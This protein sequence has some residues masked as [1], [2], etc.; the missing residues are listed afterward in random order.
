MSDKYTHTGLAHR[1]ACE[2][3]RAGTD[4]K[5]ECLDTRRGVLKGWRVTVRYEEDGEIRRYE[6]RGATPAE[7]AADFLEANEHLYG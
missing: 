6:G 5:A 1:E 2:A 4:G 3:I 7:A